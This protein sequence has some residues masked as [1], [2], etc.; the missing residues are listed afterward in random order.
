MNFSRNLSCNFVTASVCNKHCQV[1]VEPR[2]KNSFCELRQKL[3]QTKLKTLTE[4]GNKKLISLNKK[5]VLDAE[6]LCNFAVLNKRSDQKVCLKIHRFGFSTPGR[7]KCQKNCHLTL[8]F[9]RTDVE[10]K[11]SYYH[12]PGPH[13]VTIINN[14]NN[15]TAGTGKGQLSLNSSLQLVCL[16]HLFVYFVT[17][18]RNV[19][20]AR[21]AHSFPGSC[22]I[23]SQMLIRHVDNLFK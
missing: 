16:R 14:E 21:A 19:C 7:S 11:G 10:D 5:P 12:I 13:L 9:L 22:S 4:T 18:A 1:R 6:N 3:K 20:K 2:R 17:R 15:L 8:N 23:L